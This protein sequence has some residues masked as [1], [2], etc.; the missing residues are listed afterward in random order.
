[1]RFILYSLNY[2]PELTG[3]GKYNGEFAPEL[4]KRG[5]QTQVVTAPAYYP[6]WKRH[7][8]FKNWW[9][10]KDD[11][12]EVT[13]YRCPLYIPAN[14]TTLKRLL[15]LASFALSSGLTLFRFWCKKPDVVFLVQPT[16]FCAP[17]TLLYCRITGAKAVMHIQDFEVDAMFGLDMA[18]EG[19]FKH[20]T[21]RI[22]SWLL[23]R[24]D[25]VS[26]ISYNMLDNAKSKGVS[27]DKLLFFPNWADTDF[28]TPDICV[29]NIR[30]TWGYASE[31]K[32]VLYSG[33]IGAKQGLEIVLDTAEA[34]AADTKVKFVI[35]GN[36]AYQKTLKQKA[37]DKGLDNLVFKPL[38]PWEDVPKILAMANVHLVVQKRGVA[39]MVLPSK[40]TN[41][42]S[43]GGHALVTA[44]SHTE[45]GMIEQRHPGIYTLVEPENTQAFIQKLEQLLA[46]D[47]SEYNKVARQYAEQYLNKHSIIDQFI[48]EIRSRFHLT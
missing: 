4:A 10:K 17:L 8:G 42:L 31:D 5:V 21:R 18:D 1:M 46:Q 47:L 11:D 44:E 12:T 43:A 23:Q 29:N 24:F 25:A 33:N 16:L 32:I 38:Q 48:T 36:G 14:V 13:V 9:T 45:L 27:G 3:I 28:V 19:Q 39:D 40:L 22:E 6:E 26:S 20:I 7:A 34:F 15:H 37:K 41:I 35:I 2:S 30:Q